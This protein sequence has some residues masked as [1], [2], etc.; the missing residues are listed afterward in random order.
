MIVVA[1][2]LSSL[3]GQ[4]VIPPK[5]TSEVAD[6]RRHHVFRDFLATRPHPHWCR[7]NPH[8]HQAKKEKVDI[9]NSLF[10]AG[11]KRV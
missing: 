2:V 5:V 10:Q 4:V 7:L 9:L 8:R 3:F 1:Q 6:S 11:L